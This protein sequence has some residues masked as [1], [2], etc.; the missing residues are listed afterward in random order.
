MNQH[1]NN[2]NRISVANAPP[3]L[4]VNAATAGRMANTI[5]LECQYVGSS[6]DAIVSISLR[7]LVRSK[8]SVEDRNECCASEKLDSTELRRRGSAGGDAGAPSAKVAARFIILWR[9]AEGIWEPEAWLSAGA[10][11]MAR[12]NRGVQFGSLVLV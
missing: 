6:D 7:E 3:F 5:G 1:V 9:S 10:V 4:C 11:S 2:I 12:R 8:L